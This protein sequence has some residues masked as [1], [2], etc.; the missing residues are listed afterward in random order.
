LEGLVSACDGHRA[1]TDQANAIVIAT[2]GLD[3][4]D[5]SFATVEHLRRQALDGLDELADPPGIGLTAMG[6]YKVTRD[7]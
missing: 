1:A 3:G 5:L 4:Q 7:E 6:A 2:P